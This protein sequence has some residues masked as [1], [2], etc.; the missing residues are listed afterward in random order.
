VEEKYREEKMN[1]SE[2]KQAIDEEKKDLPKFDSPTDRDKA[3]PS[4]S[5]AF[6]GAPI[7]HTGKGDTF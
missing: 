1:Q 7:V 4:V 2:D 3:N 6:L 5:Q